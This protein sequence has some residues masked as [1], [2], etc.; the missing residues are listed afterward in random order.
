MDKGRAGA[1]LAAAALALCACSPAGTMVGGGA[2]LT[3]A[4]LEERTT[5]AALDDTA[6]ALGIEN[7]LGN[8]SGELFRDV[9]V[10]VTEG[11]VVL[12]G[13]VP[14]AADRVAATKAAWATPGVAGVADELVVA[15]DSGTR[16]YLEDMR[17]SNRVRYE[18]LTDLEVSSINYNVT[19]I[20]RVVHLTGI[21]VSR[22]ELSRVIDHA[23]RTRGV[24]RVVSHVLTI[25]DPR[26]VKRLARGG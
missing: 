15:E 3:R 2:V 24:E 16:A 8:H 19:T 10:D 22:D 11:A 4:V 25:G 7:R 13:S 5:L 23:R 17:I 6:I 21:A 26:R 18:L 12:T 1:T 20:D 9:S 14:R